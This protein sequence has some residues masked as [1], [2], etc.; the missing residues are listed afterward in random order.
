LEFSNV[1]KTNEQM[2]TDVKT[3]LTDDLLASEE[4]LMQWGKI[5][6]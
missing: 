5:A 1:S 4:E 6:A 3:D 2:S